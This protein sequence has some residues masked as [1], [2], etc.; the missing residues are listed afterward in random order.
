MELTLAE[1]LVLGLLLALVVWALTPL[2]RWIRDRLER[3][4]MHGRYGKVLE[5]K[6]RPADRTPDDRRN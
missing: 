3:R 5:A 6:F 2:R 4:F 1:A